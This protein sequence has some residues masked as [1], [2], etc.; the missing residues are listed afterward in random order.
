VPLAAYQP[1]Y[2]AQVAAVIGGELQAGTRL[3][4]TPGQ[5][6]LL[7]DTRLEVD[8]L[9]L[10]LSNGEGFKFASALLQGGR[11][12]LA[13]NRLEV[14]DITF[15]GADL[16][17]SRARDGRWSFLD[18]N[19]PL[20]AK[21]AEPAGAAPAPPSEQIPFSYRIG[22]INLD[23]A[24]ITFRDEVPAEPARFDIVGLA[25]T[26]RDLAA[27]ETLKSDFAVHGTFQK[28]G[29]FQVTGTAVTSGPGLTAALQLRRIPL[30]SF[31]PYLSEHVRLVL[32]D[33]ALDANLI[34]AVAKSGDT[35]RGHFGGNVGV[36]RFYCLD[37]AHREDLLRWERLQVSGIDGRLEPFSLKIA[38][39]ALN[40]YY[41]RVL[42]D[43]QARLN[44]AELAVPPPAAEAE[45]QPVPTPPTATPAPQPP[46]PPKPEIN[47]S[48]ITLQGGKVNFT[49]RHMPRSFSV[50][51]L[52]L[53][54]RIE[55]LSSTPGTRAEIDLR[56]RLRNESPVTIAG[57]V[58][59]LADPLFLNLKLDFNDIELSPLSPYSGTY[60][61]YLIEHGKM[62]VNLSYL[63]ENGR[64][65]ASN[66]LFLDQFTFGDPVESDKATS[67]PVRLAVALLKDRNGEIH[68]DIPVSGDINDPQFSVW[69]IV[70]QIIKNLLVKAATS[71]MALLGAIAGGGED[72][73]AISFPY[74]SASLPEPEQAKLLKIAEFLRD[75][76]DLKLE[77]KGFVDPESDPEAYRRELLQAK[78]RREKRLDLRKRG[79]DAA[80]ADAEAV[81][82]TGEEYPDY[83]WR[84][85]KQ[86]DFPKPRN[87]I[88]MVKHLPDPELEKLLLANTKV[89]TEELTALAQ[90]RAQ[91]VV[92]ALVETGSIPHERIFLT[93]T[94]ITA[95][96]A[97]EGVSRSRVE[98]GMALK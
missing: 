93:T 86:A 3:Q 75:R 64:L 85:Y 15:T 83:L 49:D 45:S 23:D 70:W 98:F 1:Y 97:T 92:A 58:N 72:L 73:G 9:D 28:T 76:P 37:A 87:L 41:A 12:D 20:L 5:P 36:S 56:G 88:G 44:F 61:G 69:G 29:L 33:G 94:E 59:P 96:P 63:V 67:L 84:V 66:K 2:Q 50:E 35:W 27:P 80:P 52:K 30:V 60:I 46:A 53:G 7:S 47:I 95:K 31:A 65:T 34:T 57:T 4:I 48:K 14:A 8:G 18:R 6:L 19:Y 77:V 38:T 42:L 16:R 25:A 21:L 79:G 90:A 74:G 32:V 71:P 39:I 81:T 55:G 89:D 62:N 11:F 10:P 68:L 78:I 54:G 40:D 17:F 82:V 13:A 43:E 26:I 91:A 22:R 51:M 24:Q